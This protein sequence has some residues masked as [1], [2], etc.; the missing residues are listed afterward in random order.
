MKGMKIKKITLI[1]I[2]LLVLIVLLVL[3]DIFTGI[4]YLNR[5]NLIFS[6]STF[7]NLL[8]PMTGVLAIVVYSYTLKVTIRQNKTINSSTHKETLLKEIPKLKE[9]Y[10]NNIMHI[11]KETTISTVKFF[12]ELSLSFNQLHEDE[13]YLIDVQQPNVKLTIKE[14]AKK[15]YYR[16]FLDI[17]LFINKNNSMNDFYYLQKF[18]VEVIESDLVLNHKKYIIKEI[19]NEI[20]Y[21]YLKFMDMIIFTSKYPKYKESRYMILTNE[22]SDENFANMNFKDLDLYGWKG[23]NEM[24]IMEFYNWYIDYLKRAG[25][26]SLGN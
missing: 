19:E 7:N 11:G 9:R 26:N 5:L 2:S 4:W 20:L 6:P 13:Q 23:L 22:I 16:N 14:I 25:I 15:S 21:D 12:N 8:T 17:S 18:I 1:I 24:R 3:I 10:E